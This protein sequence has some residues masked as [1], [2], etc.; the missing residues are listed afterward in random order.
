MEL[1]TA[2]TSGNNTFTIGGYTAPV[3]NVSITFG[4]MMPPADVVRSMDEEK[5]AYGPDGCHFDDD[6][7]CVKCG[8]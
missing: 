4:P 5:D 6:G 7:M 8:Y 1:A 2:T 3:T